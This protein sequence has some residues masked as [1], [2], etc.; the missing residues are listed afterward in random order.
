MNQKVKSINNSIK[1][2]I[3]TIR[4]TQVM[5]DRDLAVLYKTDTRTLKQAVNRN[6][7]KFPSDFLYKLNDNDIELM[8]SQ[9]VI[10]SKSHLGGALPYA[11]TEQG[12]AMLASVLHTDMAIK[13]SIQI[14]RA[15]VQMRSFLSQNAEIFIRLQRLEDYK[16]L[17]SKQLNRLLKA[18][19]D[20]TLKPKQGIFY[21]G[22]IFDAY[23]FVNKIIK[24]A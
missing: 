24:F 8:V 9:I 16:E 1:N 18:L 20:K 6:I 10:P 5:L 14:I 3:F 11:F 21:D 23:K 12:V 19:E 22:Q 2:K 15:F 7:K 4:G 17:S 13:V